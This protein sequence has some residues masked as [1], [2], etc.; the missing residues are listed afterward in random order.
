MR[1]ADQI[2]DLGPGT[3]PPEGRWYSRAALGDFEFG[4]FTDRAIP[5]RT[6]AIDLP[7]RRFVAGCSRSISPSVARSE[8]ALVLNEATRNSV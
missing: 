5:E 3:A 2:V 1:A 8:E 7:T 4:R 6:Q